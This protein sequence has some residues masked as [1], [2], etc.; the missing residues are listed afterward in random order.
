MTKTKR[1]MRRTKRQISQTRRIGGAARE[2]EEERLIKIE[3][4][5]IRAA[6]YAQKIKEYREAHPNWEIELKKMQKN[7]ENRERMKNEERRRKLMPNYGA[8]QQNIGRGP[9]T[10]VN[11]QQVQRNRPPIPSANAE[12]A[13]AERAN[14]ERA[15]AERANAARA[16]AERR[17]NASRANEARTNTSR[18]NAWRANAERRANAARANA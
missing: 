9:R 1:I 4:Q 12:R 15:N 14:A 16:N 6:Q 18:A 17:A 8:E 11:L 13:N 7:K 5:N 3:Q 10:T 2:T